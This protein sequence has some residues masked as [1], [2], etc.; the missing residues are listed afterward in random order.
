[1]NGLVLFVATFFGRK[2]AIKQDFREIMLIYLIF[3]T[4]YLLAY[5][6]AYSNGL[7]IDAPFNFIASVS[8]YF[9]KSLY[10]LALIR[11]SWPFKNKAI[12]KYHN[13]P[14]FGL[15]GITYLISGKEWRDL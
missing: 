12:D 13:W 3:H 4:T 5:V 8:A 15:I 9:N 2:T 11:F 7:N 6:A 1:M 10:F 14:V